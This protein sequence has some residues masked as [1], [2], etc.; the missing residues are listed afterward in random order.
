M[1]TLTM[2]MVLCVGR[3]DSLTAWTAGGISFVPR[4]I[5]LPATGSGLSLPRGY[6]LGGHQADRFVVAAGDA[7]LFGGGESGGLGFPF[8]RNP[9]G[10]QTRFSEY[11]Y[12]YGGGPNNATL[13]ENVR[14]RGLSALYFN[15]FNFGGRVPPSAWRLAVTRIRYQTS[16]AGNSY[17]EQWQPHLATIRTLQAP[18][19]RTYYLVC[20]CTAL[21]VSQRRIIQQYLL[22]LPY[23]AET[24]YQVVS[25]PSPLATTV[26]QTRAQ[27][28]AEVAGYVSGRTTTTLPPNFGFPSVPREI[29]SAYANAM[30]PSLTT[31]RQEDGIILIFGTDVLGLLRDRTP[32]SFDAA[33]ELWQ[34]LQYP[35][36]SLPSPNPFGDAWLNDRGLE[37][38]QRYQPVVRLMFFR[39]WN[40]TTNTY[41]SHPYRWLYGIYTPPNNSIHTQLARIDSQQQPVTIGGSGSFSVTSPADFVSDLG[42]SLPFGAT[43]NPIHALREALTD[44]EWGRGIPD[45]L[46]D[47]DAF[48]R[49]AQTCFNEK[50]DWCFVL[51]GLDVKPM[52]KQ[53]T[54]YVNGVL[55]YEPTSHKVTIRLIRGDYSVADLQSFDESSIAMI[56]GFQRQ[57]ANR[58][59]NAVGVKYH[60]PVLGTDE[61]LTIHDLES[62]QSIG[63]RNS[64]LTM[65]G[66]AT[67]EAAARVAARELSALSQSIVSLTAKINPTRPLSLGDPIVISYRDLGLARI[68][69]RVASID[70][71]DGLTGGVD[72][73]LLQDVFTD[74]Y[75]TDLIGELPIPTETEQLADLPD[76]IVFLELD[77]LDIRGIG[78]T[79]PFSTDANARYFKLGRRAAPA[80]DAITTVTY[81][82]LVL[83]V[84]VGRL[85]TTILPLTSDPTSQSLQII[86]SAPFIPIELTHIRV[87]DEVFAVQN[88]VSVGDQTYQLTL[89][90]RADRDTVAKPHNAGADVYLL[91]L[92]TVNPSAWDGSNIIVSQ[93]QGAFHDRSLLQPNITFISRGRLPLPP[94]WVTVN[95]SYTPNLFIDGDITIRYQA[96]RDATS[97]DAVVVRLTKGSTEL[98]NRRVTIPIFDA[99]S[100]SYAIQTQTITVSTLSHHLAAGAHNL[101]LSVSSSDRVGTNN[102]WQS[103]EYNI[104]W[105]ATTRDRKGWTYNWGNQWGSGETTVVINGQPTFAQGWDYDYDQTW[106]I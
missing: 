88:V 78:I 105:S 87:D 36:A 72:V 82:E 16:R 59:V 20:L 63:V 17:L 27:F 7:D 37:A 66:C 3:L 83:P 32:P 13:D 91:T 100:S 44:R 54:D 93:T 35:P 102:S 76:T 30:S 46:I 99:V 84:S 79:N 55:Y 85:E 34:Y 61:T 57:Q 80:T 94:A 70:Y 38:L 28:I 33:F 104:N 39:Y 5:E 24:R 68:V 52:I 1:I 21:P 14:Y 10:S 42:Q 25:Y 65:D 64:S 97:T 8:A 23:D 86:V 26:I 48:V 40:P 71:G 101:Q 103:W 29:V 77:Y 45:N 47:G 15:Q 89:I 95:G 98:Y 18:R 50:L 11:W 53:I 31:G 51:T 6:N 12:S 74:P 75:Y 2:R 96:R 69:M 4:Q 41:Y 67:R 22:A 106:D 62:V 92:M 60:D 90:T 58:V 73:Q 19:I 49:A 43:M 9:Y 56:K 81:N